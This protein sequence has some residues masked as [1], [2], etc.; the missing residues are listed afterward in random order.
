M[1]R[2]T[3]ILLFQAQDAKFKECAL[4]GSSLGPRVKRFIGSS[5]TMP[6]RVLNLNEYVIEG[7][8]LRRRREILH[9]R[10]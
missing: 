10:S 7:G 2:P 4:A 6:L 8:L 1:S 5:M 3:K 9:F